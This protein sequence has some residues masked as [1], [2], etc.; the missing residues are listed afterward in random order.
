MK[1][2]SLSQR[3]QVLADLGEMVRFELNNS[4]YNE[5]FETLLSK[6]NHMKLILLGYFI[7]NKPF[8]SVYKRV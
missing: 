1:V 5:A 3:I 8:K 6:V 4:P 7:R 2:L